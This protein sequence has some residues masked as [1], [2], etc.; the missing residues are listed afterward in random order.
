MSVLNSP[1]ELS[2]PRVDIANVD[3]LRSLLS[4]GVYRYV[5]KTPK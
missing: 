4:T 3:V 1:E 2:K 5:Y